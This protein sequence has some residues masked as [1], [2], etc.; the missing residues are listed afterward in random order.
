MS[1]KF[2]IDLY[3]IQPVVDKSFRLTSATSHLRI[4]S[5]HLDNLDFNPNYPA[6]PSDPN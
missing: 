3:V 2:D 6:D 1:I 4:I 5:A